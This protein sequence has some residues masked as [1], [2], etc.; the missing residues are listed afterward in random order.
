M[1]GISEALETAARCFQSGQIAAAE[2][3]CRQIA[4]TDPNFAEAWHLL[5]VIDLQRGNHA[6]AIENIQRAVKAD[7]SNAEAFNN[8]G[9]AQK[10]LAQWNDALVCFAKA[11]E[12]RPDFAEARSN[13]AN[14]HYHCGTIYQQTNRHDEAVASYRRAIEVNPHFAEAY[15]NLGTILKNHDLL[16]E[17]STCFRRALE[18]R[19]QDVELRFNWACLLLAQNNRQDGITVLEQ[20]LQMRPDHAEAHYNR[21]TLRLLAGD[22][23][24]G[25]PEFEWRWKTTQQQPRNFVQPIW[26]GESLSGR[27]ILLHTEQGLGDTLQFVR[28]AS[29][30]K[31]FGGRVIVECPLSLLPLLRSNREI[32]QLIGMGDTLPNFDVHAPLLS[33]PRIL[34]TTIENIPAKVPYLFAE[35]ALVARWKSQLADLMGYRIGINWRGRPGVGNFRQR[36]IPL[37]AFADLAATPGVQLISLHQG[38]GQQDLINDGAGIPIVDLDGELDKKHGAFMD[39]AAVMKNLD[40]LITSDTSIAHLAGALAVPVWLALP[41]S[42]D[43]RWLLNR[44]DSP[45]YPTMRLFR[46]GRPGDWAGVFAEIKSALLEQLNSQR[47]SPK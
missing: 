28:Y 36:D 18:L 22:F 10:S 41:F 31:Q 15:S 21:A 6:S 19:P 35:P 47:T 46:Q 13:L 14:A 8:L 32:D 23:E 7:P 34:K 4:T 24:R 5:G 26:G 42:S 39:T 44:I 3:L 45:W 17:A 9:V 11:V 20:V 43:W 27:T 1:D 30:V 37:T 2:N 38:A 33:L 16:A 12:L 25:W 40:L 29:V